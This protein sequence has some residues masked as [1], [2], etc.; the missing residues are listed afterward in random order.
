MDFHKLG[1]QSR[2][3]ALAPDVA[4][5]FWT[6]HLRQVHARIVDGISVQVPLI[7]LTSAVG[8]GKSTLLLNLIDDPCHKFLHVVLLRGSISNTNDLLNAVA[9]K[10][11]PG[12]SDNVEPL[13]RIAEG[14]SRCSVLLMIDEAQGASPQAVISLIRLAESKGRLTV[15]LAG[16]PELAIRL[17]GPDYRGLVIPS[18]HRHYL[19]PL[20]E[21]EAQSYIATRIEK[22]GGPENLI[23]P[24]AA[25]CIAKVAGNL[26]RKINKVADACLYLASLENRSQVDLPFARRVVL[27]NLDLQ[28]LALRAMP[29]TIDLPKMQEA[30]MAQKPLAFAQSLPVSSFLT[31]DEETIDLRAIAN[32]Y[33]ADNKY[34]PEQ[35]PLSLQYTVPVKPIILPEKTLQRHPLLLIS[36]SFALVGAVTLFVTLPFLSD[37][38]E[39]PTSEKVE[40]AEA[41]VAPDMIAIADDEKF[42]DSEDVKNVSISSAQS[43][44]IH[45]AELQSIPVAHWDVNA[46]KSDPDALANELYSLALSS[47][48]SV[49]AAVSYARAAL[50]GHKR[51]ARYLAQ[52]YETGDGVTFS[53]AMA[54]RW[55]GVA[56]SHDLLKAT[57][58]SYS[59]SAVP[60]EATPAMGA[61]DLIWDGAGKS[62]DVELAGEDQVPVAEF[63]S[64][65]TAASILAP[66]GVRFWRVRAEGAP[67]SPWA[68][69]STE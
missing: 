11:D 26:P 1:L 21:A 8:A 12:Q 49:K 27:E 42:A 2:P 30:K 65:L 67:Y 53:L 61:L 55:Y 7:I 43:E 59:G 31:A 25:A 60:R 51:A 46:I 58:D 68:P 62:F 41:V 57:P 15:L 44:D 63:T 9:E 10:I 37:R 64:E 4:M 52:K 13:A 47:D 48:D 14:I 19:L 66:K 56:D 40:N 29:D 24:D 20:T 17:Y 34:L 45:T 35:L 22:A 39:T 32:R 54:Q 38:L 16:Q 33:V 28:S 18:D 6:P 50:H 69:I 23:L 36:A 5:M 3:F